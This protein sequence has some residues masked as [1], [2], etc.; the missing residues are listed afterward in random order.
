MCNIILTLPNLPLD[1]KGKRCSCLIRFWRFG[2]LYV[3]FFLNSNG[4]EH[5]K[6]SQAK[7]TLLL[8]S[9]LQWWQCLSSMSS[10][11][12]RHKHTH[13]HARTHILGSFSSPSLPGFPEPN[14]EQ[15][16]GPLLP[17]ICSALL[18]R[19]VT[20]SS[21]LLHSEFFSLK[22]WSAHHK[23]PLPFGPS[24]Y[25]K[26]LPSVLLR[27]LHCSYFQFIQ[28]KDKPH[29]IRKPNL[30]WLCNPTGPDMY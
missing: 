6:K 10:L 25:P 19:S 18:L 21:Q 1:S 29:N 16:Q 26:S 15:Q 2:I 17:S 22:F 8:S 12:I 7:P 4:Y 20:P 14:T 30:A 28:T 24:E 11:S 27:T 5:I 3:Y 9:C 13:M 23:W